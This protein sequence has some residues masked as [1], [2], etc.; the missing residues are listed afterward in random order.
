MTSHSNV[1]L[2]SLSDAPIEPNSHLNSLGLSDCK[3]TPPVIEFTEQDPLGKSNV[4]TSYANLLTK[5]YDEHSQMIAL[6]KSLGEQANGL[7]ERKERL[8]ALE[9][10]IQAIRIKVSKRIVFSVLDAMAKSLSFDE[11]NMA[12]N[13]LELDNVQSLIDFMKMYEQVANL[14][15]NDAPQGFSLDRDDGCWKVVAVIIK[16]IVCQNQQA[17]EDVARHCI[18]VLLKEA[19]GRLLIC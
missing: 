15:V 19:K 1:D 11:I 3:F 2:F 4:Q 7:K 18:N 6:T 13:D 8:Y 9:R 5:D 16:V 14:T 17:L 10:I 12:L